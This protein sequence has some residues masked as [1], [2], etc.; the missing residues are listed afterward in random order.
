MRARLGEQRRLRHF[1]RTEWQAGA[2]VHIHPMSCNECLLSARHCAKDWEAEVPWSCSKALE[3]SNVSM[4]ME[5]RKSKQGQRRVD[6]CPISK[7]QQLV[8][9]ICQS[10]TDSQVGSVLRQT[11][12]WDVP[13]IVGTSKVGAHSLT[14][15]L[16]KVP[17]PERGQ[18]ESCSHHSKPQISSMTPPQ[19]SPESTYR[20]LPVYIQFLHVVAV[21]K[22]P[23][24]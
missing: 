20:V 13:G 8:G 15:K 17:N 19:R 14:G 2:L 18:R 1:S 11:D 10:E 9:L 3:E 22:C 6:A 12:A 4:A 7:S 23:L 24:P 21:S 5:G 16:L